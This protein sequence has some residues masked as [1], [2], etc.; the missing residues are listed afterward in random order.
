MVLFLVQ[1][2]A[3]IRKRAVCYIRKPSRLISQ[4]FIPLLLFI[5]TSF[6]MK[7]TVYTLNGKF[8]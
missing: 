6:A 4:F 8:L 7:T 2:F 3:L 1:I 5:M